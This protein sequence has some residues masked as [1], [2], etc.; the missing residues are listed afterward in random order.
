[1]CDKCREIV[2]RIELYRRIML[3]LDGDPQAIV[4][5]SGLI[6]EAEAEK[7]ALH[8]RVQKP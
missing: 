8:R 7:L 2:A 5:I 1:M 3:R 6:K 4:G